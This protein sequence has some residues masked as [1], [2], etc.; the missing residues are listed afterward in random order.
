MKKS[1]K[2]ICQLC[3]VRDVLDKLIQKHQVSVLPMDVDLRAVI[4]KP[5]V[6]PDVQ[7]EFEGDL[8]NDMLAFDDLLGLDLDV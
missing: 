6:L 5:A 1:P 7:L 3:S 8:V 4:Q 2:L